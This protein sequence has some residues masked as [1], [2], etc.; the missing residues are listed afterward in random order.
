MVYV[1]Q[2]NLASLK[3]VLFYRWDP[4][5]CMQMC[6]LYFIVDKYELCN[7]HPNGNWDAKYEIESK[8]ALFF[9]I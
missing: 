6:S 7:P 2:T 5:V 8:G 3:V 4:K 9:W 1:R